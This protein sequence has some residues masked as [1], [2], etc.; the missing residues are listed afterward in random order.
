[1]GWGLEGTKKTDYDSL[2]QCLFL[3]QKQWLMKR[4]LKITSLIDMQ[5]FIRLFPKSLINHYGSHYS[6]TREGIWK[7]SCK[8]KSAIQM[9]AG[10]WSALCYWLLECSIEVGLTKT[11]NQVLSAPFL[12]LNL[13]INHL[14]NMLSFSITVGLLPSVSFSLL[15]YLFNR[16]QHSGNRQALRYARHCVRSLIYVSSCDPL[17]SSVRLVP[18]SP[19]YRMGMRKRRLR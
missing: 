4:I 17:N 12:F 5:L 8:V 9:P 18:H 19:F 15:L 13:L 16:G 1:M 10:F 14:L 3:D 6:K 2:P 11:P 7:G